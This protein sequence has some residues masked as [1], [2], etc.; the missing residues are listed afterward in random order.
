MRLFSGTA[1]PELSERIADYLSVTLGDITVR[2]FSDGEIFVQINENVRGRDVFIIQPTSAPTNANLM[3]LLIMADA[4]RRASAGRITAVIPYFGYARQ[5]RKEQGRTP[6]TAKL[7][8][9]LL[10]ASGIQRV[11]TMDLHAGQIQ[12]FFNIPVDNLYASPVLLEAVRKK[13]LDNTIVV[14]PDVGGVVRARGFAK[15]LNVDLAIIDKRRPEPN[16]AEIH[17]IIGDIKGKD[18]LIVDDMVDT[19]GTMCAAANALMEQ[20]AN[21]VHA[22]VT[23][24]VLSGPAIDRIE[25]SQF[26]SLVV[27]DTIRLSERA[28]ASNK[29]EQHTV[30]NLLGEAI[31]RISDAESVSS[32]FV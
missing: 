29:I 30:A 22:A 7:V 24:G 11:L 5:D 25:D 18:C 19:A 8:A 32:L 23:H 28:S 17:H 21:S 6:I 27:A 26:D 14:S 10:E 1:N 16:K 15:R 13:K 31:R 9:D 12:G 2:R 3:E 4:F 20:G